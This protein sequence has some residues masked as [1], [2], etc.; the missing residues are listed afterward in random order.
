[1]SVAL[2]RSEEIVAAWRSGAATDEGWDNPAG[3]LFVGGEYAESELT[4][5]LTDTT[6]RPTACTFSG[7]H[8]CC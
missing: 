6:L 2:E 1:M 8:E 7:G 4:T 3:P 5:A